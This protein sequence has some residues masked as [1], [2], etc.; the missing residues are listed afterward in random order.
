MTQQVT[1]VMGQIDPIVGDISA[2]VELIINAAQQA[3]KEL[4]AD[5]IV[6]PEMTITGYPPEDLL[7]RDGLYRQ[8]KKALTQICESVHA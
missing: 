1:V 5:I 7:L 8:V 4:Q 6:F 2:N 3:K